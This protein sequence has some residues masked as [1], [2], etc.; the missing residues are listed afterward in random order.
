[1]MKPLPQFKSLF[2]VYTDN[3]E[4]LGMLQLVTN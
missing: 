2:P 3:Y 1:M 4:F